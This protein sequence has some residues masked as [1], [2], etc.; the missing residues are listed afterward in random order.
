[1]GKFPKPSRAERK[2]GRR[3]DI[4]NNVEF[5]YW[6]ELLKNMAISM[7]RYDDVPYYIDTVKMEHFL[8][9]SGSVV[10]YEDKEL[11]VFATLPYARTKGSWDIYGYPYGRRAISN[12]TYQVDGLTPENSVLMFN[13][14]TFTNELLKVDF[15]AMKL[16]KMSVARD[17]NINALKTP[18]IIRCSEAERQT[19]LN[20]YNKYD[21]AEPFIPINKQ[22]MLD[23]NF[24][25][26]NL[27]TPIVFDKLDESMTKQ[28]G[29]A[30]NALG[31]GNMPTYKKERSVSGEVNLNMEDTFINRASKLHQRQL[32]IEKFNN[33]F[34]T[35][36]SVSYNEYINPEV[37][38]SHGELYSDNEGNSGD[39]KPLDET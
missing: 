31:I 17:I 38:I 9:N 24:T 28:L 33:M 35:N 37:F 39:D 8:F 34:G 12:N 18:F 4:K 1:M 22:T 30:L 14:N 10:L 27:N 15:H 23:D 19:M 25:V 20:I 21:N 36:M 2:W 26:L 16:A 6:F 7:W 5:L 29:M 3:K 13:N 32:A 11:G